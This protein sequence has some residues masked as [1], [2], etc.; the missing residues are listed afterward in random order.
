LYNVS[1]AWRTALLEEGSVHHI[2]GVIIDKNG[3]STNIQ[4]EIADN[5]VRIEKQCTADAD[6][7]AIGQIYTG[8]VEFTLLEAS[9][10][11]RDDLKGGTV[12][13]QFGVVVGNDTD[14]TWIPLGVW[15]I[16]DPQRGSQDSIIIKGEDNTCKL[17]VPIQDDTVG[18]IKMQARMNMITRLTD[19]SFAQTIDELSEIAG[20]ELSSNMVFGTTFCATCRAELMAIAQ[21]IGGFAFINRAGEIEFRKYG[22]NSYIPTIP[23]S[24]RF[25]ASLQEYSYR[26]GALTVIN[27]YG[28]ATKNTTIQETANT[29]ADMAI[30]GNPYLNFNIYD[31]D[32]ELNETM[33]ELMSL[34]VDNL[35]SAGVW[36]PGQI[37]YYG[38]P[39]IDLGDVLTLSGGVNGETTSQFLVTGIVWQFRGPQTLISAGAGTASAT[40]TGSSSGSASS[41]GSQSVIIQQA[42]IDAVDIDFYRSEFATLCEIGEVM[43]AAANETVGIVQ[44][45]VQLQ[46]TDD[47]DNEIRI[48]R[49]GIMQTTCSCDTIASAQKHTV[50]L[51]AV[52]DLSEGIH[53]ISV[54]AKGSAAILRAVGT[55]YGQG[56]QEFTGNPTFESNYTASGGV[57]SAYNGDDDM[58]RIPAQLGGNDI[59]VIGGGSFAGSDVEYAYIPDGVEEIK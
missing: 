15:N 30:R 1:E 39:T 13:L 8:T 18:F 52:L 12:S 38:D 44:L 55:V 24:K 33:D 27:K 7:F 25:N 28:T 29:N 45:T 16:T 2:K 22:D 47:A 54:E 4:D 49:D 51:T 31:S 59:H 6:S 41:G 40:S 37:D 14:P 19:L 53:I 5:S 21:F 36:V 10:L 17:D 3:I 42:T 11:R 58:P 35:A 34:I 20:T 43:V 56:L 48:L 26:V 23:A 50:S 32:G 57:I 46:G 9:A